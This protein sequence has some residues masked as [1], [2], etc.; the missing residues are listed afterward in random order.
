MTEASP[1][2]TGAAGTTAGRV[3]PEPT[4]WTGVLAFGSAVLVLAGFFHLF[5]GVVSFFG[6]T[7]LQTPSG[8]LAVSADY[9][10]WGWAHLALGAAA[11]TAGIGVMYGRTW[12]RVLG[13]AACLVSAVVNLG[14]M[15][16][17]PWS[18]TLIV[19]FDVLVIYALVVHGR[20]AT[21]RR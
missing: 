20:E 12:A 2:S 6:D 13:V 3:R 7:Y 11:V 8:E 4:R 21:R 9:P 1:R 18:S 19:A 14:F 16:A 5:A 17:S 15:A 10:V